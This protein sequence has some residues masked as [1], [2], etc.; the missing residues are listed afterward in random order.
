[1]PINGE[2]VKMRDR[3]KIVLF[4]TALVN[5]GGQERL[6]VKEA[7]YFEKRG[8]EVKLLT[9]KL[10]KKALFGHEDLDIEVLDAKSR[11]GKIL[12]LRKRLMELKP[13]LVISQSYWDAEILYLATLF[14]KIPYVIHIHGTLFWFDNRLD[15]RKY[16]WIFRKSF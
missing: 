11:I 10:D 6:M 4:S 14:T 2:V 15:L 5:P 8:V 16:G 13:N 9:F 3:F 7:K 1:M 12:V